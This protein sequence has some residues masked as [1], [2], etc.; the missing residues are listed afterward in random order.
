MSTRPCEPLGLINEVAMIGLFGFSVQ[1]FGFC[2]QAYKSCQNVSQSNVGCLSV[3]CKHSACTRQVMASPPQMGRFGLPTVHVQRLI[4]DK[5]QWQFRLCSGTICSKESPWCFSSNPVVN[6]ARLMLQS[7][8][9]TVAAK[10]AA[11]EK[12]RPLKVCKCFKK[13]Q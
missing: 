8:Q 11:V 10:A 3:F 5:K 12:P 1:K 4:A 9:D 13:K 6:L 7:L 2:L